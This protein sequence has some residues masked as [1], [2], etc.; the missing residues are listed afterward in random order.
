MHS[1]RIFF[2]NGMLIVLR[3]FLEELGLEGRVSART[4]RH[5]KE[6]FR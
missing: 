1:L 5:F 3:P 2:S 6:L 4:F